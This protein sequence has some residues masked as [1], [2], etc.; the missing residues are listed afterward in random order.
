MATNNRAARDQRPSRR[1]RDAITSVTV[2]GFKSVAAAQTIDIAP[3]TVLAG[4]NSSGKSSI[5]QPLLLLKQTLEATYDPGPL[6]INGPNAKFTTTDQLFSRCEGTSDTVEIGIGFHGSSV[7]TVVFE[8][9]KKK[10]ALSEMRLRDGTSERTYRPGMT[11]EELRHLIPTAEAKLFEN[12]IGP[13]ARKLSWR[14]LRNRCFL[15]VGIFTADHDTMYF[16]MSPGAPVAQ[17]LRE[18]IHL[19]GLR[20]NPERTYPVSAVGQTFPGTFDKYAASVIAKWEAENRP[21]LQK[22]GEHLELLGLTWKVATEAVDET[23]VQVKVGR[24][25]HAAR[26]GAH[27]LVNIADVGVGLSQTLPIIV[28]LLTARA[29]QIVYIEQ[30]EIHLH[31]A[32]QTKLAYVLGEAARRGVRVVVETHSSLLLLALQTIVAT[33]RLQPSDV[34]LHWFTRDRHGATHVVSGQLDDGGAFGDWP[35]DFGS[36]EMRAETDYVNAA[37]L[38][39]KDAI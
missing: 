19:P 30:P 39:L 26:G 33:G 29:G 21:E 28:A 35:E 27:D 23:Q 1:G 18:L 15:E 16:G 17:H 34:R 8:R 12:A 9:E 4:A 38:R 37:S 32:A 11:S 13:R 22:L 3:L 20:G 10:L 5:L 36:V 25:P 31:P 7:L 2:G 24:L 14:V 6:L